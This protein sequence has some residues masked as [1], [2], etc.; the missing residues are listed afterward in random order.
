MAWMREG[1][2][3]AEPV[4]GIIFW[5]SLLILANTWGLYWV[6]LL[7]WSGLRSPKGAES[8]QRSAATHREPQ[9]ISFIVAAHNEEK[10]ILGRIEN[11][12]GLSYS[13]TWTEVIV[14]SDG[15]TDRTREI[16]LEAQSLWPQVRFLDYYPQRGRAAVHNDA[17]SEAKGEIIIFTDSETRFREDF[18]KWVLPHFGDPRVGAVSGRIEYINENA[19]SVTRAA[20][21]YW[22]LEEALRI[23]EA[24]LGI[25][26]FGTGACFCMRKDLYVPMPSPYD[27]VDYWETLAVVGR[28][29]KVHYEPRARAYDVISEDIAST[30][31]VRAKRTSMA[32]KSILN[33]IRVFGLWKRPGILFSVFSHKISRHLSPFF[34]IALLLSNTVLLEEG[35]FYKVTFGSQV[36]F[37]LIAALGAFG[38]TRGW[39]SRF[40]AVSFNFVALNFSR[41]VGVTKGILKK[42]PSTYR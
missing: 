36:L 27:D 28:G 14:A 23:L 2:W 34:L 11:L 3:M 24:N 20:G 25:L 5:S 10:A 7:I 40:L 32:F 38:H 4:I 16:V 26:A 35:L 21:V 41:F 31:R 12:M 8:N 13:G 19:S 33:G 22:Q 15:S 30:H 42:P 6:I 9:G 17:V 39:S 37:Y 1:F 18:L 29:F